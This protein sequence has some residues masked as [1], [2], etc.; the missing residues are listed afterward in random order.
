MSRSSSNPNG[1]CRIECYIDGE[2]TDIP[3]PVYLRIEFMSSSTI[4]TLAKSQNVSKLTA[5]CIEVYKQFIRK[6]VVFNGNN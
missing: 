2:V 6:V 3:I 5:L 4:S 1:S